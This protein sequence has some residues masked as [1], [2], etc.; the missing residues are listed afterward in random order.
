MSDKDRLDARLAGGKAYVNQPRFQYR[1][2]SE[3]DGMRAHY[4]H[5]WDDALG[6]AAE[7]P[8]TVTYAQME[9][10]ARSAGG[11]WESVETLAALA[12]PFLAALGIKVVAS[13]E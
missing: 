2:W 5:G 1:M 6:W 11:S 7:Q 9:N 8:I 10:A 4:N 12:P 13:D 3:K